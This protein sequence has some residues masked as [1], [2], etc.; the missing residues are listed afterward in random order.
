MVRVAGPDKRMPGMFAVLDKIIQAT[1]IAV[2]ETEDDGSGL[3]RFDRAVLHRGLNMLEAS[4]PL[5][6]GGHWEVASSA[7]R[8]LFE[9]L[10]NME[11]LGAKPDREEA[12][13]RYQKFGLLQLAERIRREVEYDRSTGRPVAEERLRRAT[14]VLASPSLEEF[15]GKNGK[16]K[17]S[18]SGHSTRFLAEQSPSPMRVKQY[19]QVFV[20]W[21]EETHGAPV[22]L[23]DA[24]MPHDPATW[25]DTQT[26]DDDREVGQMILMLVTLYLELWRSLP[27][28]PK[29]DLAKQLEWTTELMNEVRASG[30]EPL[31]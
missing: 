28:A 25:V 12:C 26:A 10:V 29:L 21:S 31:G 11:Y 22:A 16:W 18:W 7:A 4:R 20:T 3:G 1:R 23:L 5:L 17:P 27:H 9:L 13:L 8:Q 6:A 2:A 19:E 15:R 30:S 24:M 14:A